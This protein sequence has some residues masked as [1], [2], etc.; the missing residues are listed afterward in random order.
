[1]HVPG[2][3]P[4]ELPVSITTSAQPKTLEQHSIS[5][6]Y[7]LTGFPIMDST[8]KGPIRPNMVIVDAIPMAL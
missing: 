7:I 5:N 4:P 2:E 3:H 6:F 1:V 8:E